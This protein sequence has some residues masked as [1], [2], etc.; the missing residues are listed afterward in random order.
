MC[1]VVYQYYWCVVCVGMYLMLVNYVWKV[2]LLCGILQVCGVGDQFVVVEVFGEELFVVCDGFFF[3][4][5]FQFGGVLY[6]F[7]CFDDEGRGFV[8]KMVCMCLEL[9]VFGFFKCK[10]EGFEQFVCV[11]LDKVVVVCVDIGLIC[12]GV[13]GVDVVVQVVVGDDEVGIGVGCV[14]F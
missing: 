12:G 6:F 11:Q 7:G 13:F 3:F 4:Y 10:C 9:V 2:D 8:V 1:G 14:V 5:G